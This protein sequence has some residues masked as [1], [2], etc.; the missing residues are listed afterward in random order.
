[1]AGF[2]GFRLFGVVK[3]VESA[4]AVVLGGIVGLVLGLTGAGGSVL[5]VPMLMWGLGWTLPQAAPVAL[6]AVAMSAGIGTVAA[7]DVAVVRYRAAML[8]SGIGL[9]FAPLGLMAADRLPV[10]W[11]SGLFAAVLVIVALRMYGRARQ[12]PDEASVVR[13]N[14]GGTPAGDA[15]AVCRIREDTGR[16]SWTRNCIAAVSG[17]GAMTGFLSGM[18]GVGGGFVI[19]P[20]LRAISDMSMHAAVA[21]SL[22]T[23]SLTS[24]GTV[25]IALL[26]GRELPLVVALPFVIGAVV[27]M[28]AGRRFA[29]RVAGARLQQ[30]FAMIMGI[31]AVL[32]LGQVL[33]ETFGAGA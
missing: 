10:Q 27:G 2:A 8:M 31:I 26:H 30:G 11:L 18:L 22:M 17:T 20:A 24:A 1:M 21:T 29:A 23:I 14:V 7:W 16:I 9:L 15:G 32:M 13:A 19:V 25:V 28:L 4:I 3:V 5:A 12:N 33:W 6:I